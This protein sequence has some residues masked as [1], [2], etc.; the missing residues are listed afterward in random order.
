MHRVGRLT[1][2]CFLFLT[3]TGCQ[4]TEDS[5]VDD[6]TEKL[7][8]ST[9]VG[10]MSSRGAIKTNNLADGKQ[11]GVTVVDAGD[12]VY[13]KKDFNNVCYTA[14]TVNGTQQW[15]PEEGKDIMLGGVEGT[16]Y[17]YYPWKEGLDIE[18]IGIDL[19]EGKQVDWLYATKI[20]KLSNTNN[21]VQI[22]MN[23][24]LA[25]MNISLV[26]GQYIGKG[27]VSKITFTSD[28]IA[29]GA[30]MNA[31]TG[32]LDDFQ[33]AGVTFEYEVDAQLNDEPVQINVLFVPTEAHEPI[34]VKITVDNKTYT[35]ESEPVNT[36]SGASYNY[37]LIQHAEKL[38]MTNLTVTPWNDKPQGTL[39]VD[40]K[41]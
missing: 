6:R 25:N 36:Q 24:A 5:P 1:L 12:E 20:E 18:N 16:L 19:T 3:V 9:S 31:K 27:K 37:T 38:E 32:Q 22:K 28:A 39:E 2:L 26:K 35:V 4:D 34:T 11:I 10:N 7:I 8:I 21:K 23:H 15:L 40:K 30:T 33:D 41:K 17:A 29:S 14:Q 13:Q